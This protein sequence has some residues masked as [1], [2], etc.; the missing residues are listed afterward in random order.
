MII[1][2]S[3]SKVYTGSSIF[4]LAIK[5]ALI[6]EN[7]FPLIKDPSESARLAG[8]GSLFPYSQEI[9]VHNT[10]KTKAIEIINKIL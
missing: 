4:I 5:T 9:F 7:I 1:I 10:E 6:D 3:Y 8:F 2:S